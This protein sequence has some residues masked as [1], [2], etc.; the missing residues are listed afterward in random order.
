M[1]ER[2]ID[3]RRRRSLQIPIE[4]IRRDAHDFDVALRAHALD[5]KVLTERIP[6]AE[7]SFG[8]R[9]IHDSNQGRAGPVALIDFAT[10]QHGDLQGRKETGA[11]VQDAAD[12]RC[13]AGDADIRSTRARSDHGMI[14]EACGAHA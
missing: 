10:K 3:R 9:L 6:I 7:A 11:D 8:E 5:G 13:C 14:R 2:Q 12:F 1:R 4:R